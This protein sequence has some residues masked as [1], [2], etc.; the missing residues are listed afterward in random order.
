MFFPVMSRD[1]VETSERTRIDLAIVDGLVRSEAADL[2][3]IACPTVAP[4]MDWTGTS[5]KAKYNQH[6]A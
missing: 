6:F 3:L 2:V 4:M 1:H 5:R